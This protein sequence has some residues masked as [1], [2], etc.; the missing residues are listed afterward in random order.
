M[1]IVARTI[2]A[3]AFLATT[4][5]SAPPKVPSF[6]QFLSPASPQ[7][8]VA[9]RKVDRIAWVDYAEGKRNAYTAVA[10]L[11]TPVRLTNFLKDDGIMMSGIRISDDGST[12][13]FLRGE[14]PN[15]EGWSPNPSADPNGPEHAVWAA[16][17]NGVGGAWRVADATNPELAPDGSAILFVKDGQIYRAKVTPVKPASEVD[18]GEKAFITE[19]GVQSQP[20]WSPDGRKIAYVSTRTDHSF[21]VVY[22]MATRS[23]KYMSPSVDF[24]TMPMWLPDSKHLMFTRRPGLPFGQQAQQGGGGIGLSSG[25]AFQGSATATPGGRGGGRGNRGGSAPAATNNAAAAQAASG[26]GNRGGQGGQGG[27]TPAVT[28]NEPGVMRATFKGGYTLAIYKADVTTGE[29]QETWHNQ[30]NDTLVANL[31]NV[32][33]AGD[34]A[35]FPFGV[36]G[37][38]GGRGGRAGRGEAA[39]TPNGT[40]GSAPAE[41]PA[42]PAAPVDEW[43]RYY[44]LNVM[45]PAARP[46]L[47]TTTDGLIEDQTSIAVSGDGKT[48]Y[49][50]TNAKDIERRHIWAVPTGGGAPVEITTGE[51]VETYPAPLASGKYLATLSASWNMPQSVGVWKIGKEGPVGAAPPQQIIFPKSRPGFPVD[52]HVKPE[53]VI[54]KAAD[55]LEIHNQL[56][57]P[58]DLKPGERRPAIV[59]VHGGPVRQMMPAYHYMQFY[60]WAYGINEWLASQGYVVMSINYRSGIGYGRSFRTAPNTGAAGNSEYQD[61]VAGGKYLQTRPDVDPERIGIWGL[62]Y[63]GLLTSEALARNS[64]IF[65]AGVDLAGVHLEGSS[66][67]P[68]AV[69]YKS[70]AIGAID[71]WKSPVLL[72]QGDD[73]RNVAFQ[74]ITGLVQLLRQRDVYYE[75]I[76]FPDDVHESLLH[77]RWMYTLGR[78]ETFLHKFLGEPSMSTSK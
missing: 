59:F 36:G 35:I 16:R 51:G 75:L 8:L 67:D 77:S 19:W 74:Q 25:P 78:M 33:L 69:S 18:R 32:H 3:A 26:R 7:D 48:F 12:V 53:I 52:A 2:L 45:D 10:P 62:S 55:G 14:A 27:T 24:D 40:P 4:L 76:V 30:P 56:F 37:R 22:D 72:V 61:V 29:A 1:R 31:G 20:K 9:A 13:V 66:L 47:L 34:L 11:F 58:K 43:D 57:L 73:D 6:Q 42:R 63:G 38:G 39:A 21:I 44:A 65:K 71:S 28:N 68:A 15:R 60:H 46:V 54:T 50:C 49:Y 5:V 23:V 41:T 64:D 17:T 70:S